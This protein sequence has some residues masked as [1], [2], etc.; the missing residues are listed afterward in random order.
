MRLPPLLVGAATAALLAGCTVGPDFL[1]PKL[2]LPPQFTERA[3][4]PADIALT[5]ARLKHWWA[6]FNDPVLNDLID[7]AIAGNLDLQ[8]A[9]QR[10]LEA[11]DERDE[12]AAGAYP[13]VDFAASA[14]RARA[15]TTVEYPPGFGNYHA[16][17]LG[18][19]ASW[20]LDIFGENRRAT[21]AADAQVGQ[22][23]AS[24]RALLVSLLSE[25]AADYAT[26]RATQLRLSIAQDN[27]VTAQKVVSLSQQEAAQ[28]I[29]TTLGTTQ[30]LAQLEQ[31]QATLPG[32]QAEI[33][34]MAHAIGVLA[35]HY[36]GELETQ[37]SHPRPLMATP[38]TIPDTIPAEVIANR[39]DV[40]EAELQYAAANAEIGVAIAERLPHFAIPISI[41]PQASAIN[42]LFTFASL[43]FS[44]ALSATQH[45]YEGGRLSARERAARAS[46]E[47]A[48]L[49][50]KET[51][52]T[53]LREVEDALVHMQADQTAHASLA[54]A[55]RYARKS[56]GQSTTLYNAGLTDFLTVLTD[57]RTLFAAR[58]ALAES[59]LTLV[60]DYIALFKALGGGW[61]EIELDVPAAASTN[62]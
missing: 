54:S 30:A 20:E 3:A 43:T 34:V 39:P 33:A 53:A 26:L 58:D 5:N 18:F 42:Q 19:D 52:L 57:E 50:Y 62:E 17:Q 15:S 21:E 61:Q 51:V 49:N 8:I 9:R 48:R 11:R 45:V 2:N 38:A 10:L 35:G 7:Q 16:L 22:S 37:L 25:V 59:D 6:S 36:P 40:H 27:V 13:M 24:R 29:G 28:G 55:V 47:A 1:R 14:Q 31:T 12:T 46:A 44:A 56:L 23:I 41:T 60:Q 32:L 4:T